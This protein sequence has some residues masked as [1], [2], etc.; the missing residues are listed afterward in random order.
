MKE[1]ANGFEALHGIHFILGTI[2]GSHVP[3]LAPS[4]DLVAY[5]RFICIIQ[6]YWIRN[7]TN[8]AMIL[9]TF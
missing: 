5:E 6:I 3:I 1:I 8:A 7:I 9:F 2:D 4:H